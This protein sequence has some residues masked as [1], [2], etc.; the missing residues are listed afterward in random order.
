MTTIDKE[1]TD[2][3]EVSNFWTT[4]VRIIEKMTIQKILIPLLGTFFSLP[5]EQTNIGTFRTYFSSISIF[6]PNLYNN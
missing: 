1:L 2:L 6:D 4:I 5:K 3:L